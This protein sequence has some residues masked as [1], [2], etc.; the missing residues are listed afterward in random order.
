MPEESAGPN[1]IVV[2]WTS[3][4]REVALKM[5]FM[6]AL[7]SKLKGWWKKVTL[8]V[9]GP[10]ARLIS[11]DKEL[12][13]RLSAMKEAGVKLRACKACSDAYGVSASLKELG[14]K[15]EYMGQPLTEFLKNDNSRVITF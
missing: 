5:V 14:I 9:W 15:V 7:N 8:I 11:A 10:S 13:E 12:Q 1:E 4:D 6:Y 2:L 3:G